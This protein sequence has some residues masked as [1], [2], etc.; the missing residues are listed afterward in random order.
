MHFDNVV[1]LLLGLRSEQ[2]SNWIHAGLIS[3]TCEPFR[4][5]N[6]IISQ[7]EGYACDA[8]PREMI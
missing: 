7:L 4:P 8:L 1:T 3:V 6:V 5:F 2:K